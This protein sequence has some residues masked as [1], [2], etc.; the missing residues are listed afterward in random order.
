MIINKLVLGAI[1]LASAS[2][3]A[4]SSD[5]SD[6]SQTASKPSSENKE[7]YDAVKDPMDMARGVEK[8]IMDK[9]AKD[10]KAMSDDEHAAHH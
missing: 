8:T 2:L 3:T 6:S 7:L 10:A 4:C 1:I 5:N 9:A